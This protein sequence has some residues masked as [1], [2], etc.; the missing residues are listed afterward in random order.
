MT[1]SVTTKGQVTIPK[2]IRDLLGIK[3]GSAVDFVLD[4]DGRVVLEIPDARPRVSRFESA[5]GMLG[6]G[7]STDEIMVM[8]RG[9]D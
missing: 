7:P 4:R 8:L 9:E 5:R 6:P 2:S 1:T 3:P